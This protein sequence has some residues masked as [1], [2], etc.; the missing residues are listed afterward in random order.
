MRNKKI[1]IYEKN[2]DSSAHNEST[3]RK[4]AVSVLSEEINRA[5]RE[6]EA[7]RINFDC[8]SAPDEVD[9]CIYGLRCAQVRY[10][11]LLNRLKYLKQSSK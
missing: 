6:M 9:I 3:P 10:C 7:A 11:S 2:L 5:R 4:E 1:N 8:V